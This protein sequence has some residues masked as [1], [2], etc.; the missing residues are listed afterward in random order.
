MGHKLYSIK[1]KG[2]PE[3]VRYFGSMVTLSDSWFF[4]WHTSMRRMP[5]PCD[6]C[7]Q[8]IKHGDPYI[9]MHTPRFEMAGGLPAKDVRCQSCAAKG[10][11]PDEI[12]STSIFERPSGGL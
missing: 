9:R 11:L 8:P 2:K 12:E 5:F 4:T 1:L 10:N 7:N 6:Y 3:D